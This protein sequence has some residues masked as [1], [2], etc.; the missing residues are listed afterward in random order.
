MREQDL[1]L[2]ALSPFNFWYVYV[3]SKG[4]WECPGNRFKVFKKRVGSVPLLNV[5]NKCVESILFS[6][7]S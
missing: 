1:L 3:M 6:G 4:G 5:S 7:T 2:N